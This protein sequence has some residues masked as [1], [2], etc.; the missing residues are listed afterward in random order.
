MRC[1]YCRKKGHEVSFC[2]ARRNQPTDDR[3][4]WTEALLSGPRVTLDTYTGM[5]C[6]QAVA[7]WQELGE[8]LNQGNPWTDSTRPEESLRSRLGFWK[9]LGADS[10]TLSWICYGIPAPLQSAPPRKWYSNWESYHEHVAFASEAIQALV[11]K[12]AAHR[13]PADFPEVVVPLQVEVSASGKKRLCFDQRPVN[14]FLAH[15]SFTMET[16]RKVGP[17]VVKPG[18]KLFTLDLEAAYHWLRM[19]EAALPYCCFYHEG[20]FYCCTALPFGFSLAPWVFT[21]VNRPTLAFFRSLGV[22]LSAYLD[23]WLFG[24]EEGKEAETYRAA[25]SVLGGLGWGISPKSMKQAEW[26]AVFLGM[27]IDAQA[28]AY[29]VP[30]EKIKR[31]T[32]MTEQLLATA[33][34]GQASLEKLHSLEGTLQSMSLAIPSIMIW[35]RYLAAARATAQAQGRESMPLTGDQSRALKEAVSLLQTNN[36]APVNPPFATLRA[37]LDAG[38][39]GLGAWLHLPEG[40]EELVYVLSEEEMRQSSTHRELLT[41]LRLIQAHG[42]GVLRGQVFRVYMD[43][44]AAVRILLKFGS[45][46]SED[47]HTLCEQIDAA[48]RAHGITLQP[49][50]VPRDENQKAD[51]L[52]KHFDRGEL[53]SDVRRRI[54]RRLGELPILCPTFTNVG[55]AATA[56]LAQGQSAIVV[57]PKWPSQAWWPALQRRTT[58]T[59][60]L[61][62]YADTFHYKGKHKPPPWEF[63]ASVLEI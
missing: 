6:A 12:G 30:E 42:A 5:S 55:Q 16:L 14:A 52:S 3:C 23:D 39:T 43:S 27:R 25:T 40:S 26:V 61:G 50:W 56:A 54:R 7:H 2:P 58:R 46:K 47:C 24:T 21:K 36:G 18:Q 8:T 20:E 13:V 17:D 11:A 60:G 9:A 33:R 15:M 28:M 59:L 48:C 45:N 31:A 4:P 10:N 53:R 29:S 1:A 19:D 51:A 57:H 34:G 41:V 22:D 44:S 35:V 38:G 32:T 62:C 63:Q 49:V 37:H